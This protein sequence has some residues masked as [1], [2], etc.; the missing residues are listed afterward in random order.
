MIREDQSIQTAAIYKTTSLQVK[1]KE[2]TLETLYLETGELSAFPLNYLQGRQ[3]LKKK[4]KLP[5]PY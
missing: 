1:S 5:Y 2:N 4:K 3:P